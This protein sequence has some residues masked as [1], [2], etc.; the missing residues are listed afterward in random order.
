VG[1]AYVAPHQAEVGNMFDIRT[2]NGGIAKATIVKTPFF[3]A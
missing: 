3:N 1:L 2:D